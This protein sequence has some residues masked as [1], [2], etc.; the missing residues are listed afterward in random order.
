KMA[1][2]LEAVAVEAKRAREFG[3]GD[4]E[5]ERPRKWML[6]YYERAYTERDKTESGSFAQEYLDY[7][8]EDEPSPGIEYEY[9]LVQQLSPTITRQEVSALAKTLLSEDGRV[10][11]ATS[12]EKPGSKEPTEAEPKGALASAASTPVTTWTDT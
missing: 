5:L 6:A 3:F 1:E 4:A 11:L 12:P 8:L 7:F 2:G 9:K 10:I